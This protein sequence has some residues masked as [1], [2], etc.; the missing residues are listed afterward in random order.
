MAIERRTTPHG[1][2]AL[3]VL[4]DTIHE[5]QAGDRLCPV[6]VIVPSNSVGVAARRWLARHGGI[7]AVQFLT[8][9]RL[10]ELLGGP[11]LAAGGRQPVTSPVLDIALRRAIRTDGGA[12]RNVG[13]H[14][15]TI[16][17]LRTTYAELRQL[18]ESQVATLREQGS[19]RGRDVV[20]VAEV[21]QRSLAPDWYDERDL[22]DAACAAAGAPVRV[23]V[24]LPER[25]RPAQRR[26]VE[27]AGATGS[28]VV[29]E[30][31][32]HAAITHPVPPLTVVEVTDADE[33]AREAVRQVLSAS[34]AGVPLEAQA[35]VWPSRSPYARV[36]TDQLTAAGIPWNGQGGTELRE[37]LAARVALGWLRLDRRGLRRVDVFALLAQVPARDLSGVPVPNQRFERVSRAAG[38]HGG[39]DWH[40]KLQRFAARAEARRPGSRDAA[41]AQAMLAFIDELTDEL[42]DPGARRMPS[43]WAKAVDTVVA[44]WL[45]VPGLHADEVQ[46]LE[47]VERVTLRLRSLDAIAQPLTRHEFADLLEA[48][49]D[50]VPTRVGRIGNGVQVGPLSFT[51]GQ[52]LELLVVLGA[53]DG[54]LPAPP[55]Q[56]GLLPDRDRQLV[57]DDLPRAADWPLDQRR[58]FVASLAGATRAV[59]CVPLGD[60]R[61]TARR[62]RS[63]LV[64]ELAGRTD[65]DIV[66]RPS[67]SHTLA[68]TDLPAT[69]GAFR[70]RALVAAASTGA[71]LRQHPL[72]LA[73]P[74]LRLGLPLLDARRADVFTE[75]DGLLSD[76]GP[77]TR[78]FSPTALERWSSCPWHYF[79]R[80]ILG[81]RQI[82]DPEHTDSISA[83]DKGTLVHD[84][85]H[86]LHQA[87]IAGSL[88]QPTGGWTD[89]HVSALAEAYDRHADDAEARGITGRRALWQHERRRQWRQ[90]R[91]WLDHDSEQ[92]VA[93][94]ARVV[95]SEIALPDDGSVGIDLPSQ[96]RVAIHGRIDRIDATPDGL[97]VT[98][99]KTGRSRSIHAAD[100]TDGGTHLQLPLYALAAP[101]LVEADPDV[102]V[103]VE[104]AFITDRKRPSLQVDDTVRA[105]LLR[106]LQR[107]VGAIDGGVFVALPPKPSAYH[108]WTE[109]VMCDPDGFG[110]ASAHRRL[111]RKLGDPRLVGVLTPADDEGDAS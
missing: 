74:P 78:Q 100:P 36:V 30:A 56:S 87:V 44:R 107:I 7:A 98:D 103:R 23:V 67:F 70:T 104:Y 72:V 48:E 83:A 99:L 55:P 17:A 81:V 68:T 88:P 11:A 5:L 61:A 28:V 108:G 73:H 77:V 94:S 66:R 109:C 29:I 59:M 31:D 105:D 106:Q 92:L 110:T 22:L 95:A 111:L 64:G 42:G 47:H 21:T 54:S 58:Q 69:L 2:P 41:D 71:D 76:I 84:A 24:H 97:V 50:A 40:D 57:G 32:D 12:L 18:D 25:L 46:A 89:I 34:H 33:E 3:Q 13:H 45:S 6:T 65:V 20:R 49:L 38:V 15:A 101:G 1:E 16:E 85:L 51:V 82:D 39:G 19:H 96:R 4:R 93:R 26:L 86:D 91:H 37:R 52:P 90:L 9:Y 53:A 62:P 60:L 27:H 35:I 79:V 10:A 102:P 8:L 80:Y 14:R 43:A 75:Y 63:R